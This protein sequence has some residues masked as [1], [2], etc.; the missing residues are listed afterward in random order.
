MCKWWL[1]RSLCVFV[2]CKL[3]EPHRGQINNFC[4]KVQKLWPINN[5]LPRRDN[6]TVKNQELSFLFIPHGL[7][8]INLSQAVVEL[9]PYIHKLTTDGRT[10]KHDCYRTITFNRSC[11]V[12]KVN[13]SGKKQHTLPNVCQN[14]RLYRTQT[15]FQFSASPS[16]FL[17]TTESATFAH[18][19]KKS[20]RLKTGFL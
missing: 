3:N 18:F 4:L 2:Q 11:N 8:E 10:D 12:L 13:P 6:S 7:D 19:M 1:H 15:L 14:R 17:G 5:I 16:P 20:M 9:W